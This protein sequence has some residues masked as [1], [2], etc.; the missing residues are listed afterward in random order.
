MV[1]KRSIFATVMVVATILATT[2]LAYEVKEV[3]ILERPDGNTELNRWI[4]PVK[5]PHGKHTMYLACLEC[6]HKDSA[7]ELG[8]FVACRQCHTDE[9]PTAENGFYRAWHSN[10]PPS[11]LGC[12]ALTRARGGKSPVGCTSACHKSEKK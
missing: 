7:K 9:D 3:I 1:H 2:A 6:H 10:G 5:F 8:K 12:H 11:C 4:G